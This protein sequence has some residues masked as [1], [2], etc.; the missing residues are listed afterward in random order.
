MSLH[1]PRLNQ[2]GAVSDQPDWD[3]IVAHQLKTPLCALDARLSQTD[4]VDRTVLRNDI[5]KLTRLIDQL[6]TFAKCRNGEDMNCVPASLS[7]QVRQ[8][9][10]DLA[11]LAFQKGQRLVFRDYS[12]EIEVAINVDLTHEALRNIIENAIKYTPAGET[13][14]VVVTRAGIV[15]VI[16]KGDGVPEADRSRI[17]E[18]FKRGRKTKS[19]AGTGLGLFLVHKIMS[20]QNGLVS[21]RNRH[22]G[23]SVFF[24]RFKK[25]DVQ[26]I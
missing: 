1:N 17:F 8:V 10:S 13:I 18:P 4:D 19:T 24:L 12:N 3:A 11:P 26:T 23:G 5:R 22:K 16:D 7:D 20:M 9:C 15:Y 25:A 6:Q 21:Q 14:D 2:D